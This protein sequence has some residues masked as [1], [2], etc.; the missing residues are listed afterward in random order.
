MDSYMGTLDREF[1][2]WRISQ[3]N[4]RS[5]Y[6]EAVM[7]LV[8]LQAI[9]SIIP[10]QIFSTTETDPDIVK[11]LKAGE[12]PEDEKHAHKVCIQSACFTLIN[13]RL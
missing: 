2:P 11:Y 7:L 9:S 5:L 13:E 10:E 3:N 4:C 8:Y 6:K 12:L 1:E